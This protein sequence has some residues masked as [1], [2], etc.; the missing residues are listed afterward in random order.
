M[1][2]CILDTLEGILMTLMSFKEN[3]CEFMGPSLQ[4]NNNLNLDLTATDRVFRKHPKCH[5]PLEAWNG[6]RFVYRQLQMV[7]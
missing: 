6:A 3:Q 1:L 7:S 2:S 4:T 5:H